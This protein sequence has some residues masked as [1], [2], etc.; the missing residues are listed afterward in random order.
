L[1]IKLTPHT[2]SVPLALTP[3]AGSEHCAT[4]QIFSCQRS[5]SRKKAG[6]LRPASLPFERPTGRRHGA[7]AHAGEQNS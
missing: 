2:E 5:N 6:P 3:I 4:R 1:T 7:K